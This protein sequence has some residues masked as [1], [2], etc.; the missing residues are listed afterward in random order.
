MGKSILSKQKPKR[1]YSMIKAAGTYC[2]W[3][4]IAGGLGFG[5]YYFIQNQGK[6]FDQYKIRVKFLDTLPDDKK[7]RAK[8]KKLVESKAKKAKSLGD[9][10][11]AV[12]QK[13]G[14]SFSN[15]RIQAKEITVS[16]KRREAL[17]HLVAW[18]KTWS[19]DHSGELF[20][21]EQKKP[22]TVLLENFLQNLS[23]QPEMEA[24]G[25][26]DLSAK[27][28]SKL[29]KALKLIR[30]SKSMKIKLKKI[31]YT[32]GRGLEFYAPT[33]AT[34][35]IV[36]HTQFRRKLGRYKQTVSKL[37]DKKALSIDLD[38]SNKGIIKYDERL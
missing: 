33:S 17:A 21:A 26:L 20:P 13:F 31:L 37:G 22:R 5:A 15:V 29:G 4:I 19:L 24:L 25:T 32:P 12:H 38:Y 36:G 14:F 23:E 10:A 7:V 34:K 18:Q 27:S 16:I 30:I 11:G 2:A 35:V 8:I 1:S 9:L 28:K 3:L 6:G